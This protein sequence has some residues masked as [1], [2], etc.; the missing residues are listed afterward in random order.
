MDINKIRKDFPILQR[1]VYGKPLVYF[2]NAATTQKPSVVIQALSKYYME[3]N[4][5]IHRA[6]H[7]LGEEA[8]VA[9]EESRKN[10][11]T[12][13]NAEN[14]HE[15]IFTKGTTDSI[16]LVA[17]SFGKKFF[18]EGDEIIVSTLEHHSNIVPWQFMC[19]Q[20]GAKLRVI[21]ISDSGEIIFSEYQKLLN[22]KTKLVAISHVSN[23]I[24]TINPV[25]EV[26]KEAHDL[27][28]PVLID[29]PQAIPHMKIDVQELDCDFYTFSSHKIYGPMGVGTLYGK[30]KYLNEMPPYQGGG[31]MINNV[32]FEKTTYNQLPF[33]FE[34]GT[35][36][37]ADV[38]GF[39]EA[40][41]YIRSIGMDNIS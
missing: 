5:N 2:D 35:P 19:E 31:E 1:E 20:S 34:A 6:A 14:A 18:K 38:I 29:G 4:S 8:T 41:K 40:I 36:N 24:G 16:N 15:I 9:Y 37:V 7:F 21:P 28:I 26:I 3:Q 25:K 10:V 23:A 13:I 11:Q 32:S 27:N 12:F 30:E 33:K 39:S 17:S 22:D